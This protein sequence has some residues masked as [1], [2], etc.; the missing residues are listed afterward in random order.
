M[1]EIEYSSGIVQQNDSIEFFSLNIRDIM[2]LVYQDFIEVFE[3]KQTMGKRM[4]LI[5]HRS[6]QKFNAI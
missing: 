5:F 4:T 6:S 3:R 2:I 1:E